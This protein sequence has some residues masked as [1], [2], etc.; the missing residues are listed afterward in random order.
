MGL[1]FSSQMGG[2]KL[3]YPSLETLYVNERITEPGGRSHSQTV[4]SDLKAKRTTPKYLKDKNFTCTFTCLL[5]PKTLEKL[6]ISGY[7]AETA[8]YTFH[9]VIILFILH[10]NSTQIMFRQTECNEQDRQNDSYQKMPIN[11]CSIHICH[12]RLNQSTRWLW[13]IRTQNTQ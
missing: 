9:N 3:G 12:K 2:P 11:I 1:Q 10:P 13:K 5:N 6:W 4:Q 8:A 7:T